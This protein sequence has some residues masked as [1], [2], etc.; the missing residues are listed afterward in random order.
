MK[1][2]AQKN[3]S[4]DTGS[5]RPVAPCVDVTEI[6]VKTALV[7]SGIPGVD[8]VINPYLGCG[9]GCRYCYA[10][11]M[12]KYA[13]HHPNAAWGSFVEVKINI[14]QVLRQELRRKK[15]ASRALLASV[16]DPYQ[17]V[18]QKFRL[19][20]QCLELLQEFGWGI[21]VLTRSP[22]VTR[23]L[24][25]L[26]G[27]PGAT[28]GLSI[29]TDDDRVR[30]VLEPLAPS[31]ASRVE[32]LK[33]LCQAGLKPWVFIAPMLPM[34]PARLH[35]LIAPYAGTV[36]MDPLNYR[37]QV[38]QLFRRQRWDYALTDDFA[39]Q[40]RDRLLQVFGDQASECKREPG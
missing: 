37:G 5:G 17:P 11:F 39:R 6:T 19:T 35:E 16:C 23:D 20:R 13:R 25:L 29:P 30:Q 14:P 22:L 33:R 40:T 26:A 10:V 27:A 9:H 36:M 4:N 3:K 18:E 31:I 32:A 21:D 34:Q 28:V 24:D 12:K 2:G 7:R 8:Y 1:A 15:R 38:Q